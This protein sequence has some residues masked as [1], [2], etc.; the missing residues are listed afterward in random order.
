MQADSFSQFFF[1]QSAPRF[2][3]PKF[4]FLGKMDFDPNRLEGTPKVQFMPPI[5]HEWRDFDALIEEIL[6]MQSYSELGR[7]ISM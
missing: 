7:G 6:V 4:S 1:F 3:V 2:F 5:L